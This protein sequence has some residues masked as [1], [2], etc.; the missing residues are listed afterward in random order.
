MSTSCAAT[1]FSASRKQKNNQ[2][3]SALHLYLTHSQNKGVILA[4]SQSR[5]V[6]TTVAPVYLLRRVASHWR[7]A[8]E[9]FDAQKKYQPGNLSRSQTNAGFEMR[10]FN[11]MTLAWIG[12]WHSEKCIT[13]TWVKIVPWLIGRSVG[14]GIGDRGSVQ[15]EWIVTFG[16]SPWLLVARCARQ[17]RFV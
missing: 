9:F 1:C 15:P 10:V 8:L 12:Q 16:Q 3:Q 14:L 13:P 4:I 7:H 17:I 11:E 6:K 2:C 5:C